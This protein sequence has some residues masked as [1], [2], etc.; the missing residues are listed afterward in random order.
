MKSLPRILGNLILSTSTTSVALHQVPIA[1]PP[2]TLGANPFE[3]IQVD[4]LSQDYSG[5]IGLTRDEFTIRIESTGG[6]WTQLISG[7]PCILILR[8]SD[9]AASATTATWGNGKGFVM[10]SPLDNGASQAVTQ[11][12]SAIQLTPGACAW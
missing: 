6:T 8:S 5:L 4:D 10:K 1:P 9:S 2:V 11:I 12:L 7:D 3:Y